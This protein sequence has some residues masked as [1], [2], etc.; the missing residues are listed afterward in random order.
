[1]WNAQI[2]ALQIFDLFLIDP[3]YQGV[4][5]S[6]NIILAIEYAV[7]NGAKIINL[8]LGGPSFAPFQYDIIQYAHDNGVLVVAAAGNESR[9]TDLIPT[10]P[11]AYDLPN[12]VSV[13]SSDEN[14]N[15]SS[16]SNFGSVTVDVAAPGGSSA[17]SNIYSTTPP[18]RVALFEDDF[19]SG[20]GKWESEGRV[21][22]WSVAFDPVFGSQVAQDSPG[23]YASSENSYLATAE[24]INATN[25]RGLHFQFD[26]DHLLEP[27]YDFLYIENSLDGVNYATNYAPLTGFSFGIINYND[28]GSELEVDSFYLRFRLETD[29][30]VNFDGVYLDNVSVTGIPWEFTGTEYG[31]KRGTSMATPVVAGV[32]GLIWSR[33][34]SLTHLEVRDII[35]NS[36]DI[37]PSLQGKTLTGGRVNAYKALLLAGT[38]PVSTV[39]ILGFTTDIAAIPTTG[40]PIRFAVQAIG[41]AGETLNYRFFVRP[42]YGTPRW[43]NTRW[44]LLQDWSTAN[45]IDLSFPTPDNYYVVGHVV[46]AGQTWE[47]GDPQIGM[48][49]AVHD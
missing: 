4:I 36:V 46:A 8:S 49:I 35:L 16:F 5:Q 38:P 45:Y 19:E 37:L 40:T 10:Y 17:V 3:F 15:L 9:N 1:M 48:N 42:G 30:T 20:G 32:A 14:D 43:E 44:Q 21:N 33:N 24:P 23:T 18:A 39:Q 34:P 29:S 27:G 11:A 41:P 2:M 31:F 47:S 28:W 26:I 25:A 7:D 12:I 6:V 22:E 13:A